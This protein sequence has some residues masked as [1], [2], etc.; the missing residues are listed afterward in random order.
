VTN[1][2]ETRFHHVANG[3]ATTMTIEAGGIPGSWSI[4]ADSLYEGPVPGGLSDTELLDV[5][6]R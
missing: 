5:R 2:T 3:T 6:M 1:T 4:W